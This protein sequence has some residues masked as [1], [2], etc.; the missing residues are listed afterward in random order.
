MRQIH[1]LVTVIGLLLLAEVTGQAQSLGDVA[2]AQKHKQANDAHAPRKVLTNEDMPEPP[3]E[4]STTTV[5][6]DEHPSAPAPPASNDEH[7]AAHWKALI[8]AQKSRIASLQ[9]QIDRLNSSVHFVEA[10]HYYNGV[11]H[12]ERQIQKQD[13]VRRMQKQQDEQKKQL[14]DMQEQARKAGLGSS[15]YEP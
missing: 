4:A 12:N 14:E 9:G 7:A 2:R 15:V 6:S 1:R 8:Q 3:D 5:S 11:Q 10:D 13:E